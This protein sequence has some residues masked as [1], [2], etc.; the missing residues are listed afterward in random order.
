MKL[1]IIYED[2]DVLVI[3]KPAG[4]VVFNENQSAAKSLIDL[5]IETHPLLKNTGNMPRYGVVH[6]LDKDT[7]GIILIAKN[8]NALSFLQA[9]FKKRQV[10]KRYLAL[11]VGIVKNDTETIKTLIDRS[12]KDG[13]K[14]K[15]FSPG[16]PGSE[17]KREA[18]TLYKVLKRFSDYTLL[19]ITPK[20]GRKHQI[21]CHLSYI[22]HPIAGDKL[23]GF[24]NQPCPEGLTRHFLHA[25][26]L[27]IEMPSGEAPHQSKHGTGQAK[28][29][30]S[31]LKKHQEISRAGAEKK[32]G[33]VGKEAGLES[34][35]LHTATHLLHRALREVLGGN[36]KQMGSDITPERLRFDFSHNAK[37]TFEQIKRV[38]EI[39]NEKIKEDIEV[40]KEEM[41]Y[42]EAIKKGS[43]AFFREKYPP[44]VNVYSIGDYSK[45]ICAG[46]HVKRTSELG[47]FKILKEESSSAGVRRIRAVL[48]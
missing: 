16:E 40:R 31:E 45:E 9:Q 20:T 42:E 1:Q 34:A 24:K 5:L 36:V 46:P 8:D 11:V 37:M 17:G 23:Y 35:K 21:R 44:V 39:V 18:I 27:R 29:F 13:I 32:F 7:S 3:D 15:V 19:E 6:R 43:L 22:H 4:I 47:E 33:G 41:P 14:Q 10:E 2:N 30:E 48:K 38:E 12:P 26:Y 25:S 28:E